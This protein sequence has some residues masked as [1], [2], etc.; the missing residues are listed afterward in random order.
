MP[1]RTYCR[2]V[3]VHICSRKQLKYPKNCCSL[4]TIGPGGLPALWNG[5]SQLCHFQGWSCNAPPS[6]PLVL[7]T[8]YPHWTSCKDRSFFYFA[9]YFDTIHSVPWGC[10]QACAI[11]AVV[12]LSAKLP[13]FGGG[14]FKMCQLVRF[15]YCCSLWTLQTMKQ[16]INDTCCV[17]P[18]SAFWGEG[19][20]GT[21]KAPQP[22]HLSASLT[23][24]DP[25]QVLIQKAVQ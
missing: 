8:C 4:K 6:P 13:P 7:A 15:A 23:T 3:T 18:R 17:V 24:W 9:A 21:R 2:H 19:G 1:K 14:L 16:W 12:R 5:C 10:A 11:C 20:Q 25:Q 22:G